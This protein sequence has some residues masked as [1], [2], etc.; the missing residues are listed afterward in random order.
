MDV[1]EHINL[2]CRT[3]KVVDLTACIMVVIVTT[4]YFCQSRF[5]VFTRLFYIFD[6]ETQYGSIVLCTQWEGHHTHIME[7]NCL[8]KAHRSLQWLC[9]AIRH[10]LPRLTGMIIGS[11]PGYEPVQ[12]RVCIP[13]VLSEA[14]LSQHV[15]CLES[16]SD[17]AASVNV[18][19]TQRA[20]VCFS[21]KYRMSLTVR[22]PPPSPQWCCA[23]STRVS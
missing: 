10:F 8:G 18:S 9:L 13:W 20:R 11:S 4:L 22:R 16:C 5:T 7:R 14:V 21:K 1:F 12:F 6:L 17:V 15:I 2:Q 23:L 19:A 3:L